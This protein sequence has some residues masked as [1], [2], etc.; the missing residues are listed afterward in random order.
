[1][2]ALAT[3]GQDSSTL[4]D[5][6]NTSGP[7]TSLVDIKKSRKRIGIMTNGNY[8]FSGTLE[9]YDRDWTMILSDVKIG[10]IHIRTMKKGGPIFK[11]REIK[12]L[13]LNGCNIVNIVLNP[14]EDYH[15]RPSKIHTQNSYVDNKSRIKMRN[16]KIENYVETDSDIKVEW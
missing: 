7:L 4:Q 11:T 12:N 1:M 13:F 10:W 8:Y 5:R 15:L 14:E 2:S 16:L 3:R 9:A 6:E